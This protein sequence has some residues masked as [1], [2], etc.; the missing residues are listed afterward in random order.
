M[1]IATT[2][3]ELSV[4]IPAPPER[5]YEALTDQKLHAAFTGA[6]AAGKPVPGGRFTA[7]DGYI[8]GSYLELEPPVRIVQQWSTTEWPAGAPPSRVEFHLTGVPEG[9]ELRL[10]HSAVPA[11]QAESYR[12]GWIDYYWHPLRR[13]FSG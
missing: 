4:V 11:E 3:F 7:W 5:V 12:Q 1:K 6:R 13:Y 8:E 2:S 9:T 10:L